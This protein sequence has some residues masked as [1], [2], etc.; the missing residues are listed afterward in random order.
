MRICEIELKGLHAFVV[1]VKLRSGLIA[2]TLVFA[3][4]LSQ[5]RALA[6]IYGDTSMLSKVTNETQQ[7]ISPEQKVVKSLDD[8]AKRLR[9]IAPKNKAQ[10]SLNKAKQLYSNSIQS[11]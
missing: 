8:Q 11:T 2:K 9:D 1:S 3:E 10:K 4:S 7:N 6:N 5:A